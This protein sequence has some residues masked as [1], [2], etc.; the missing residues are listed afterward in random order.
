MGA[1]MITQKLGGEIQYN[2]MDE[3]DDFMNNEDWDFIL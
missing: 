1:N 3:F 2:N